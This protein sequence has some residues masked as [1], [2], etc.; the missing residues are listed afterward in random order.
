[1]A[2]TR[3]YDNRGPFT[4][5]KICEHASIPSPEADG[6]SEIADLATLEGAG[7]SHLTFCAAK[8]LVLALAAFSCGILSGRRGRGAAHRTAKDATRAMPFRP[9][10]TRSGS[11]ALLSRAQRY[12]LDPGSRRPPERADR[13]QCQPG[14]WSGRWPKR[15][16]RRWYACRTQCRHRPWRR[17]R[18]RL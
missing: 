17:R 10:R 6:G 9:A 1:M 18:T 7:P 5:A 4:L 2:D 15:R 14:A 11:G 8:D 16:D 3:F 12:G 13:R